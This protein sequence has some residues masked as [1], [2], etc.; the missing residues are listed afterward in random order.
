MNTPIPKANLQLNLDYVLSI[1]SIIQVRKKADRSINDHFGSK[2]LK[3]GEELKAFRLLHD[4]IPFKLGTTK[5]WFKAMYD[6]IQKFY[7]EQQRKVIFIPGRSWTAEQK[8]QS[9]IEYVVNLFKNGIYE[10]ELPGGCKR[11]F[12]S[13]YIIYFGNC[14]V[15]YV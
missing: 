7:D 13:L 2:A 12:V 9:R 11:V 15:I 1:C 10:E 3:E 6:M 5:G 4:G 14:F 8:H